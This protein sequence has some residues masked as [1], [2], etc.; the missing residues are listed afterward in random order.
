[1]VAAAASA[2]SNPDERHPL[3]DQRDAASRSGPGGPASA[4]DPARHPARKNHDGHASRNADEEV[5]G[6]LS[7][8]AKIAGG[9]RSTL[10]PPAN[11]EETVRWTIAI[12]LGFIALKLLFAI[13]RRL[14]GR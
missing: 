13:F 4:G 9:Q 7:E 14:T 5:M 12:V 1:V 11:L 2:Q 6:A 8:Y 10:H 3:V